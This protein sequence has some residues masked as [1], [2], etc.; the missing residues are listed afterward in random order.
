LAVD[1]TGA[2]T[3]RALLTTHAPSVA[4]DG[5]AVTLVAMPHTP[6]LVDAA[7]TLAFASGGGSVVGVVSGGVVDLVADVCPNVPGP[8]GAVAQAA[9]LAPLGGG[10][11]VAACRAGTLLAIRSGGSAGGSGEK[12]APHL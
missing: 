11:F 9:G 12:T 7:G 5:G 2:E 4:T 3:S 1:A 10:A 8:Q 6:L